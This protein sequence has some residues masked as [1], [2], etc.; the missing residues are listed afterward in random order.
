MLFHVLPCM[1]SERKTIET[2]AFA[3]WEI[4][5]R[6]RKGMTVRQACRFEGRRLLSLYM[7]H[8]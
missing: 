7:A 5:T 6:A 3:L 4:E 2:L 8:K 1:P